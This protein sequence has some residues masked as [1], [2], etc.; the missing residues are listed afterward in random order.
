MAVQK[1]LWLA[2]LLLA[3]TS[4]FQSFCSSQSLIFVDSE[5]DVAN[6]SC[7]DL[8]DALDHLTSNT[9]LELESGTHVIC[10]SHVLGL[11]DMSDISIVGD[12]REETVVSCE[13]EF[14]LSF[15]NVTSLMISNLT[16]TECGLTGNSLQDATV[17]LYDVIDSIFYFPPTLEI[18]IFL[19]YCY[20][21]RMTNILVTNTSGIGL[22]GVNIFGNSELKHTTFT[23]NIHPNCHT[24]NPDL[25]QVSSGGAYFLYEDGYNR[26]KDLNTLQILNSNFSYNA[27]CGSAG[28]LNLNYQYYSAFPNITYHIGGGGG[29]SLVMAQRNYAVT[30]NIDSSN[31]YKNDARYGGGAY[32]AVFS[33]SVVDTIRF[34]NCTFDQNGLP[35]EINTQARME[36]GAGIALLM[37]MLLFWGKIGHAPL[38]SC[39]ACRD[40]SII[41]T[42]FTN[43]AALTE[44]GG[45]MVFSLSKSIR[46]NYDL[47]NINVAVRFTA[48]RFENNFAKYGSALYIFQKVTLGLD[49]ILTVLFNNI[50]VTKSQAMYN[51]DNGITGLSENRLSA[52]DLR[53]VV[54]AVSR[55]MTIKNNAVSGFYL[56]SSLIVVTYGATLII[57]GNISNRGGGV[58]MDG[59]INGILLSNDSEVL[60]RENQATAE[61]G[62]VYYENPSNESILQPVSAPGCI[63]STFENEPGLHMFQ[64]NIVIEF[65]NNRAPIGSIAFGTSLG[66][67]SWASQL[68]VSE[69][70][71]FSE[72]YSNSRFNSTFIFSE[73]PNEAKW[74]STEP[75][76]IKVDERDRSITSFPG[77]FHYINVFTLDR[78]MN[79]IDAIITT[80]RIG[81]NGIDIRI[82]S[83]GFW[84]N[85]NDPVPLFINGSTNGSNI[86]VLLS[87]NNLVST[88]I[89]IKILNCPIGFV[90]DN[91]TKSC[92]CDIMNISTLSCDENISIRIRKREW[93]GCASQPGTCM[94]FKDLVL[95]NCHFS[96]CDPADIEFNYSNTD[97]QCTRG[98][99][100]TGLMCGGC[101]AGYSIS[102]GSDQCII[103]RDVNIGFIFGIF[104]ISIILFLCISLLGLTIDKG[105][106]N[107]VVMFSGIVFPYAF[108]GASPAVVLQRA[109]IPLKFF[110]I[111]FNNV[112]YSICLFDGLTPIVKAAINFVI[113]LYLCF[114]ML[115]FGIICHFST[116]M[117]EH[118]SPSKTL[119]SLAHMLYSVVFRSSLFIIVPI[120]IVTIGGTSYPPRWLIDPNMKYFDGFHAALGVLSYL[121]LFAYIIP[122]PL[123]VFFPSLAYKYA[124]RLKPFLDVIYAP[125]KPKCRF[126]VSV[127]L[128]FSVFIPLITAFNIPEL[129]IPVNL[130]ALI[131]FL[132][133]QMSLQPFNDKVINVADNFLILITIVL[134]ANAYLRAVDNIDREKLTPREIATIVITL[135]SAY[136][137]IILTLI[138]CGRNKI[139]MMLRK[140]SSF[141]KKQL[142]R[143][144][145]LQNQS[146]NSTLN[147]GTLPTHTS[148]SVTAE[149]QTVCYR[150]FTSARESILED[151]VFTSNDN[152]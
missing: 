78:F 29:F 27:D 35:S 51:S 90:Y 63:V 107:M 22:L 47:W 119:V 152:L 10:R 123:V 61:G 24:D 93:L 142:K 14:A 2:L 148:I 41:E 114:F 5:C 6:Q 104:I 38:T 101:A 59:L 37:D 102:L 135:S 8:D 42:N 40:I 17:L 16:I 83:S 19:G 80:N 105:W 145:E 98:S 100:R 141:M 132:Y 118:F 57:E 126:W 76:M 144:S 54:A 64:W 113:P 36:G 117:S 53:N 69:N 13:D 137:V 18:G 97:N 49:G 112:G 138:I 136:F 81:G 11:R 120:S 31:F 124:K 149:D 143:A 129:A 106:T 140:L 44:G 151:S 34:M 72:L 94:E 67:C 150:N 122:L 71:I 73:N 77:Q 55:N 110:T 146:R 147:R 96:Y 60:F 50:F 92:K 111:D 82:G 30:V 20:N 88:N 75:Y 89:T 48:S 46:R 4:V 116:Y 103:C 85:R 23:H 134:H 79:K 3:L 91:E 121:L 128:L 139:V 66:S 1:F 39:N 28:L 131:F 25:D 133:L 86:T 108:I 56:S 70:D 127:R 115:I 130:V 26:L 12:G 62:A 58:Y 7:Y 33:S 65:T 9:T 45:V 68:N 84:Y 15:I 95:L 109:F 52:I 87:T 99:N 43:N 21:F 74:I 32:I 125:F